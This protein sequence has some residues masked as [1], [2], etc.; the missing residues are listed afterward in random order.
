MIPSKKKNLFLEIVYWTWCLPQTLLGLIVKLIFKGKEHVVIAGDGDYFIYEYN[1][2]G[3]S[4]SL[5]KY[6][7][8]SQAA[9]NDIKTIK[10]EL[11]HQKQSFILGPLYLLVIGIPSII[12]CKVIWPMKCKKYGYY[13][14]YWFWTEKWA[15]KLGGVYA[16]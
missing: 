13:N 9:K 15:D 12:W 6:V 11:G 16:G 14:Y 7:L 8:L 2:K 4:I 1:C 3:G 5:G 10:H